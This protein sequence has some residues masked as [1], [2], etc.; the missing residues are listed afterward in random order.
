MIN[1]SH[2]QY[3]GCYTTE[4]SSKVAE[5]QYKIIV[6]LGRADNRHTILKAVIDWADFLAK[7]IEI[8]SNV[9][10]SSKCLKKWLSL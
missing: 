5:R 8:K 3:K 9:L 10:I 6:V 7:I 2:F 1:P 4:N